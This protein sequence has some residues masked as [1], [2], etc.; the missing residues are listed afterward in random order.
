MGAGRWSGV[1]SLLR[2]WLVCSWRGHSYPPMPQVHFARSGLTEYKV[3]TLPE[4]IF[5]ASP[6]DDVHVSWRCARC[7]RWVEIA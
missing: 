7:G 5:V 2:R 4:T 1:V 3:E 6:E